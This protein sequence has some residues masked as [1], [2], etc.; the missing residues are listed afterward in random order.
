MQMDDVE[1]IVAHQCQHNAKD[2]EGNPVTTP[3][4]FMT[5]NSMIAMRLEKLRS[6]HGGWCSRKKGGRQ[7]TCPGRTARQAAVLSFE[8]CSAILRGLRDQPTLDGKLHAGEVGVHCL[9]DELGMQSL[10]KVQNRTQY[11]DD[12]AKQ[13]LDGS[14]VE[15]ARRKNW[16]TSNQKGSGKPGSSRSACGKLANAL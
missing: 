1:T 10:L 12:T 14:L 7:A 2:C 15:T 13:P 5:N 8:L 16:I 9:E 3:T 4:T 6:G 11:D